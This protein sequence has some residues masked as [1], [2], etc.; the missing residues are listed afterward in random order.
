MKWSQRW[1]NLEIWPRW[2]SKQLVVI[3]GQTR[4]LY[5]T[6][7]P[8]RQ[9]SEFRDET[10]F[11]YAHT[12]IQTQVVVICGPMR[13]QLDHGGVSLRVRQI[14]EFNWG[15]GEKPIHIVVLPSTFY[16]IPCSQNTSPDNTVEGK[17]TNLDHQRWTSHSFVGKWRQILHHPMMKLLSPH[18]RVTMISLATRTK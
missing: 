8:Q 10:P 4:C 2:D 5:H 13:Y 17:L 7:W 1:N 18:I 12:K 11:R 16:S 6:E 15:E 9:W 3:C 14:K